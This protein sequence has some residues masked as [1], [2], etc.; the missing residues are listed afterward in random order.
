[1]AAISKNSTSMT[2]KLT[3]QCS[4]IHNALEYSGIVRSMKRNIDA[5][6]TVATT[7]EYLDRLI[8]DLRIAG[9]L[10]VYI[11]R[12]RYGLML[13]GSST[14]RELEEFP[15]RYPHVAISTAINQAERRARAIA[16]A[17]FGGVDVRMTPG[18]TV[19]GQV[20]QGSAGFYSSDGQYRR[21]TNSG[22]PA[23]RVPAARQIF[24]F[25]Y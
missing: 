8:K 10:A 18:I 13:P 20:V 3:I 15:S 1:M 11:N 5:V 9:L 23:V 19:D 22:R 21:P 16:I 6:D 12:L 2:S 24:E 25:E 17:G 7:R 4:V 14:V